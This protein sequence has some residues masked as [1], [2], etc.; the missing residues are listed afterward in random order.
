MVNGGIHIEDLSATGERP[1]FGKSELYAEWAARMQRGRGRGRDR[2]RHA[3]INRNLSSWADYK[4]WSE[5]MKGSFEP[6]KSPP[7]KK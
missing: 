1:G 5:R 2:N 4:D 6:D 3:A 7:R